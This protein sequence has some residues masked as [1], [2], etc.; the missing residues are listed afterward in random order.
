MSLTQERLKEI[1]HYN[2]E[3]GIFTNLKKK[4]GPNNT[5]QDAG[6]LDKSTGYIRISIDN[7]T[8]RIHRLAFLYMEGYLPKEAD[9]R[10]TNPLNN[11]WNNLR[12][13]SKSQNSMNRNLRADNK[14]GHK[15][16]SLH[17]GLYICD[18]KAKGIRKTKSFHLEEKEAALEWLHS[19]RKE[20]H[21][22]FVNHGTGK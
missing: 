9:H 19:T 4:Q 5:K 14:T 7:K 18:V 13:C 11:S 10:D 12:D 22:N 6:W 1:L 17:R 8:Y 15:G 16:M 21:G 3:T 20:L 2:P